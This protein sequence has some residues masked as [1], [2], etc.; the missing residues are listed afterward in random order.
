MHL[1]SLEIDDNV[2]SAPD[3][4]ISLNAVGLFSKQDIIL[5]RGHWILIICEE[6]RLNPEPH[7]FIFFQRFETSESKAFFFFWTISS[8]GQLVVLESVYPMWV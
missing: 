5:K 3:V 2:H 4:G 7:L 6:A 1:S 8:N